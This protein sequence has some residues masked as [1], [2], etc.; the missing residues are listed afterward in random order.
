MQ[1]PSRNDWQTYPK[2]YSLINIKLEQSTDLE[3]MQEN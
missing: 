2:N 1:K 3:E